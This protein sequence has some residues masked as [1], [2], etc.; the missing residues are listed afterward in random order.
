MNYIIQTKF[1]RFIS[2]SLLYLLV[3]NISFA[4]PRFSSTE[5]P[6]LG[7][8]IPS[9][10]IPGSS[11][12]KDTISSQSIDPV[13]QKNL[14]QRLK[15]LGLNSSVKAKKL[16]VA[17]IDITDIDQPKV[18]T[19]NGDRMMYAASLPKIAILFGAF[20]RIEDG[21]LELNDE[22]R[23]LMTR[24]IRY[25]S[26][27]AASQVLNLVG[28]EYLATLLQSPEYRLY[29]VAR[30]GG[31]WVGK[32]YGKAGAW[33]RD[34]LHNLS[35]GATAVQAAR[36]Y[37]MLEKGQ[38][39]SPQLTV[40]MKEIL[41]KPSITHKF[42]KGLQAIHPQAEVYRKS[43]TWKQWHSD[44]VMVEH[45]GHRYIAVALAESPQGGKWLSDLIVAIDEIVCP[46]D[47]PDFS[48]PTQ[49][50]FVF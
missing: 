35:H 36:F 12:S 38:L 3:A 23:E 40:D 7:F 13:L 31:L 18:A 30:N 22:T 27:Q 2:V 41:S 42:V 21:G 14:E 26:N 37:Y 1:L 44:S 47:V 34:P 45:D 16:A 43:G 49:Q 20:Q 48:R 24:M 19:V 8:S 4:T 6:T 15:T 11:T 50:I 5:F 25:S 17:L 9:S 28:K 46:V 29:D 10:S 32:S 39:V 33:K